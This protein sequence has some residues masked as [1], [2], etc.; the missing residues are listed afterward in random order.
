[1][2]HL[3][4]S[5]T[6]NAKPFR[7]FLYFHLKFTQNLREASAF[8][9][10]SNKSPHVD[11]SRSGRQATWWP[12]EDGRASRA[13]CDPPRE[14]ESRDCRPPEPAAPTRRRASDPPEQ[15]ATVLT[16]ASDVTYAI[17]SLTM[18]W[19]EQAAWGIRDPKTAVKGGGILS[20]DPR[21]SNGRSAAP[22]ASRGRC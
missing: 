12:L 17:A 14:A 7:Y 10:W 5:E 20:E 22:T 3:H 19:A 2:R 4:S 13:V 16:K 1:M 15:L 18:N 8:L 6:S 9:A 21:A 11:S